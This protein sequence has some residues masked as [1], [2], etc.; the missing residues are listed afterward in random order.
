MPKP[1]IPPRKPSTARSI[2][3]YRLHYIN[4][5]FPLLS[6]L[7]AVVAGGEHTIYCDYTGPF[8][9]AYFGRS[10]AQYLQ[11]FAARMALFEL[12]TQPDANG[13]R[14][15]VVHAEPGDWDEILRCLKVELTSVKLPD[16]AW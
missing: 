8:V 5:K 1:E 13:V 15:L 14:Q 4:E 2:A 6:M 3:N 16:P 9:S 11:D 12:E 7:Y 10:N